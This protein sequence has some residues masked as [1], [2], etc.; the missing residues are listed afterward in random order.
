MGVLRVHTSGSFA[1][2]DKTFSAQSKGH[3][4]AV[5]DAITWL[6]ESVLPTAVAQDLQ[7]RKQGNAPNDEFKEA[8]LRHLIKK[9]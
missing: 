4:V 3:A 1:S 8:D 5:D 7:L 9:G 2:F 6:K